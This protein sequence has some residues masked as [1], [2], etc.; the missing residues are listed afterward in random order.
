MRTR[1]FAL[2]ALLYLFLATGMFFWVGRHTNYEQ[3]YCLDDTYIHLAIAKN[4]LLN[5]S[6]GVTPHV[7]SAVS[8]SVIWPLIV[9]ACFAL[10]GVK[11]TIPLVLDVVISVLLL[12]VCHRL[13]NRLQ[14]QAPEWMQMG[15]QIAILFSAPLIM[16]T[17]GGMEHILQILADLWFLYFASEELTSKLQSQRTLIWFCASA[18]LAASVRYEGLFLVFVACLL[19]LSERQLV[20]SVV[21]GAA[22]LVPVCAMGLYSVSQGSSFIPNSLRIKAT[23]P[24]QLHFTPALFGPPMQGILCSYSWKQGLAEIFLACCGL[25]ALTF[26]SGELLSRRTRL[27][28]GIY[29]GTALLHSQFS[30]LGWVY[31]Y[32]AYLIALG[33]FVLFSA[34]AE[35][36]ARFPGFAPAQRRLALVAALAV[37]IGALSTYSRARATLLSI[38][39]G[40]KAIYFQ[41]YQM[42]RFLATYYPN[43]PIAANDIG[44]ITFYGDHDCLDLVGLATLEV[45]D[46]RAKNAFTTDQIQRLAE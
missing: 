36:G 29:I 6:F 10:F 4:L 38:P 27:M 2:G 13:F 19:L 21:T 17:F 25:F 24:G 7:F 1:P 28:L 14:P 44:A 40:A 39:W 35:L 34:A 3:F 41:Q 11:A 43:A 22:A 37:A 18:A 16:L 42:A 46:L 31:R 9:T 23:N 12:Y 15:L 45:A 26:F 33:I 20:T 5:H 30:R 32:E 8:S